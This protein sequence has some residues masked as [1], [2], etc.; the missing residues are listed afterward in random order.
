MEG[1]DSRWLAEPA[2]PA[3]QNPRRE[4]RRREQAPAERRGPAEV[5][6]NSAPERLTD[7]LL[8]IHSAPQR[9]KSSLL[10]KAEPLE[11]ASQ[12]MTHWKLETE[13]ERWKAS[14]ARMGLPV[15]RIL[16]L[17]WVTGDWKLCT[18]DNEGA[19]A[20]AAAGLRD[21]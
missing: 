1:G 6:K 15:T 2:A 14:G 17:L 18:A 4:S 5:A 8:S 10:K 13:T 12:R 3:A 20:A 11:G 16:L 7:W 9:L 19:T 21:C